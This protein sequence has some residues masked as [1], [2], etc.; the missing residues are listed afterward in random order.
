MEKKTFIEIIKG[1]LTGTDGDGSAKRIT[2]FWFA[3]VLLGTLTGV[4]E[5][6]FYLSVTSLVPTKVQEMVVRMYE[7]LHYSLQL[8]I[9]M[10]CGLATIETV[11]ALIKTLKGDKKENE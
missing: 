2:S 8:T 10:L 3:V 9:W 1:T 4:Y 7:P 6:C 5:H 11:T